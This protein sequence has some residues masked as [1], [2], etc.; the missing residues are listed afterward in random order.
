MSKQLAQQEALRLA[1]AELEH[2]DLTVRCPALGLPVPENGSV[3]LRVFGTEMILQQSGFHLIHAETGE[4]A[5]L[6]DRILVL[7]YLL[8]KSPVNLTG[9]LISFRHPLKVS[10]RP[11]RKEIVP[12]TDIIN[13]N[14]RIIL[15]RFFIVIPNLLPV[16]AVIRRMETP[17]VV[18]FK[19][20]RR[21]L[22]RRICF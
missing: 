16:L 22:Q 6:S 8:C 21:P 7:H 14:I 2:V 11:P 9:E 10:Y 4:P 5:K 17:I 19:I 3:H 12:P 18:P 1:I 15:I 13:R 20:R